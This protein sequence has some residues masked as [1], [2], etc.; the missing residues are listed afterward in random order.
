MSPEP[1]QGGVTLDSFG[2]VAEFAR[3]CTAGTLPEG[4]R[5]VHGSHPLVILVEGTLE[6]LSAAQLPTPVVGLNRG[7]EDQ[8]IDERRTLE[9]G[10]EREPLQHLLYSFE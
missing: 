5:T 3:A 8:L 10:D 4:D 7:S 2:V 1:E 6:S 9:D